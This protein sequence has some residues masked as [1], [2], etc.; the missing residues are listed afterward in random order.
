MASPST[1]RGFSLIELSIVLVIIALM[2]AAIIGGRSLMRQSDLQSVVRDV[3]AIKGG[4]NAFRAQYEAMPGDFSRASSYWG[5]WDTTLETGVGDGN[6]N[7]HWEEWR[8]S[9]GVLAWHHMQKAGVL[10]GNYSSQVSDGITIGR[11]AFP[12]PLTGTGYALCWHHPFNLVATDAFNYIMYGKLDRNREYFSDGALYAQ[13]AQ[14]IDKKMDDGLAGQGS[15]YALRGD[16]QS[17]G[18]TNV[19]W[20]AGR[21]TYVLSDRT[22][23]CYLMFVIGGYML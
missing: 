8:C 14:S 22:N 11:Q 23:T 20:N 15:I 21:P 10:P 18:C 3:V 17:T 4:L 6:G 7:N 2:V 19:G 12:G 1:L 13:E 5:I 16:D 9:E